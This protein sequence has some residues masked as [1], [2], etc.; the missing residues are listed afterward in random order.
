MPAPKDPLFYTDLDAMS[1]RVGAKSED[2]LLVWSS[3]SG[4]DPTLDWPPYPKTPEE[5]GASRTM[6]TLM[7]NVWVPGMFDQTTWD[8]FPS[9]S[10]RQ[11]LPYIEKAVYGPARRAIGRSFQDTFEVYLAN[12]ASGM[13]RSDGAYSDA[14][15]MYIG[16]N[17]P[18]NWAMD[19]APAGLTR[20]AAD[21]VVVDG[22]SKATS[23]RGTYP[24]ALTLVNAGVLKGYV[25]LG[26]LRLFAKNALKRIPV[27]YEAIGYLQNVR[28]NVA[29]NRP[30]DIVPPADLS[31]VQ[32][33]LKATTTP[34]YTPDFDTS[35]SKGGKRDDRIAS[36]TEAKKKLP[37]P[38]A[39]SGGVPPGVPLGLDQKQLGAG[40]LIG[41]GIAT[42]ATIVMLARK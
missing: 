28:A 40:V 27:F 4:I 31:Y 29:L 14:S 1:Q 11:Q 37:P 32:A 23:Q 13:L 17:Y 41:A 12:A 5:K 42:V 20:A 25:S 34:T 39:S 30:A 6:S 3:E 26:D 22:R 38:S 7:K 15:A 19:N 10:A 24:Y 18:D 8:S 21:H 36:P 9:M 16:R 33:S 2:M 35:F